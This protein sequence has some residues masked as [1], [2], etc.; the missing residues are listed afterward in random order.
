M[1]NSA[2]LF[3]VATSH[4][5]PLED[6]TGYVQTDLPRPVPNS[7][8][9]RRRIQS[10]ELRLVTEDEAGAADAQPSTSRP[11]RS[12]QVA[13]PQADQSSTLTEDAA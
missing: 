2:S 6:G 5:V 9:Y 13:A 7:V 1:S 8:Y 3:V 4:Q 10:D 11:S 12:R